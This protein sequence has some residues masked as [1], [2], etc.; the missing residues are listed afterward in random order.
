MIWDEKIRNEVCAAYLRARDRG[1]GPK[2]CHTAALDK[3][4]KLTKGADARPNAYDYANEAKAIHG[5]E[6]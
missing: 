5:D 3:A 2:A 1:K 4:W 6:S